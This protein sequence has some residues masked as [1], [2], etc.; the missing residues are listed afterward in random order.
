MGIQYTIPYVGTRVDLTGLAMANVYT[1]LP[2]PSNPTLQEV[3][4]AGYFV[5]NGRITQKI[6]KYFEVYIAVNNVFDTD[7]ETENG[8]P[9]WG[10]NIFGGIT[11][12]F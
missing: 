10:R 11:A 1:Q 6:M 7:Y 5:M 4:T 2:A 8:Y 3:Q 12:R 9:A